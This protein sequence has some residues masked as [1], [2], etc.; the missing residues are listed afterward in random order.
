MSSISDVIKKYQEILSE[1]LKLKFSNKRPTLGKVGIANRLFIM[2]LFDDTQLFIDFLK[3]ARLIKT[4]LMCEKCNVPML[5]KA[6][7]VVS[8]GFVFLCY[9]KTDDK[10]C[11]V[12]RSLRTGSWF[13]KSGLKMFEIFLLTYEI[14]KGTRTRDIES[15]YY[16]ATNTLADYRQ[17]IREIISEY[18]ISK[19]EKIGGTGK[20][21]ELVEAKFGKRKSGKV[22]IEEV[23]FFGGLEQGSGKVFLVASED[24]SPDMV[25]SAIEDFVLPGTKIRVDLW[26]SK[27]S[28][29]E[30]NLNHLTQNKGIT[31]D[32]NCGL[33]K[34]S[35]PW[36]NRMEDFQTYLFNKHCEENNVDRFNK[37]L[38]I[39]RIEDD[40][41]P[42]SDDFKPASD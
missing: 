36:H 12:N 2:K 7:K 32:A 31:F 25:T 5:I 6:R 27:E 16:F 20:V 24:N 19:S 30:D 14:V 40:F 1:N 41:K 21:V 9:Q 39:I 8:D 13:S 4:H 15:E 3:E 33:V 28:F 11:T 23:Y 17:F 42:A 38:E 26:K 22:K 37:F 35:V 34:C 18:L 29:P 10:K